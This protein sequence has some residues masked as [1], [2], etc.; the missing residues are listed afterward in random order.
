MKRTFLLTSLA[1][2]CACD[3]SGTDLVPVP[4]PGIDPVI[5]LGELPVIDADTWDDESQRDSLIT[6]A[7]IG[8]PEPGE[9]SGATF[10]FRGTG[11]KVCLVVDPEAVFW[12]TS[13]AIQG[14]SEAYSWPDNYLDDGDLDMMAG[15]SANYTGS[16]GVE[17]G[18]FYG[19]YTD[20]LG[21][22]VEIE[23]NL[24][25]SVDRYGNTPAYAGRSTPEYC[26][27]NTEGREGIEYTVLLRT[28]SLPIDDSVLTF[29]TV[30]KE[31]GCRN[32][33]ECTLRSESRDAHVED[34]GTVTTEVRAG[35]D[36][37]EDAYCAGQMFTYC[38]ENP[39]MCGEPRD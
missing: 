25:E 32:I 36:E 14:P 33:D 9:K 23:Y 8:A 4:T 34:D 21:N 39:D 16:P 37:L 18:D 26:T 13:V 24:C 38:S 27:I 20:S 6:Y 29:A 10:T 15:F 30:V 2:L 5:E 1:L 17:L 22:T 11:S 28:F 35:Y 31:G 3:R 7:A 19:F 12:N